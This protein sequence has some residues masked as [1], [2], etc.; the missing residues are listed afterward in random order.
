MCC[1]VILLLLPL[2]FY[3]S[4]SQNNVNFS[5]GWNLGKAKLLCTLPSRIM[6]KLA[7]KTRGSYA[8]PRKCT[9]SSSYICL[10]E[11]LCPAGRVAQAW[12]M[13]YFLHQEKTSPNHGIKHK[14][15]YLIIIV[16]LSLSVYLLK[17][18]NIK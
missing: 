18:S 13:L 17:F 8:G 15:L 4:L 9:G 11:L 12:P 6:E 2:H 7:T 3:R 16:I 5:K 10:G 14:N 1:Q